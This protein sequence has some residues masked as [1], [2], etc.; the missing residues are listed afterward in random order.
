MKLRRA[1]TLKQYK[2][3]FQL[4]KAAFPDYERKPLWMLFAKQNGQNGEMISIEEDGT[5]IGLA[6]SLRKDDLVLLDYFA[7]R[8]DLRGNGYGARALKLLQ[9]YYREKKFFLEIEDVHDMRGD[10]VQ[11]QKRKAFYLRNGM[12]EQDVHVKLFGTGMELLGYKTD[13]SFEEYQ[14]LYR[15][16]YG[17]QMI[18]RNV[19][20][21]K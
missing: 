15:E 21:A 17:E 10:L 14:G 7:V 16:I 2:N 20:L 13:V 18:K 12:K 5:F 1:K 4:Y 8:D 3:I 9:R 11:K 6:I 19:T